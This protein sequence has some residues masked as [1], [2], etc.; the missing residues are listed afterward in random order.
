[1][2]SPSEGDGAPNEPQPI[3][4]SSIAIQM[5]LQQQNSM[6]LGT[7]DDH[8]S[9]V[10]SPEQQDKSGD[11]SDDSIIEVMAQKESKP[12]TAPMCKK[13]AIAQEDGNESFDD[14]NGAGGQGSEQMNGK[15]ST[16]KMKEVKVV[17]TNR[18]DKLPSTDS[19]HQIKKSTKF[20]SI[21]SDSNADRQRSKAFQTSP[22]YAGK[23]VCNAYAIQLQRVIS[24]SGQQCITALQLLT[25][26]FDPIHT[27]SPLSIIDS[28]VVSPTSPVTAQ[29][30]PGDFVPVGTPPPVQNKQ[31]QADHP[32]LPEGS[33]TIPLVQHSDST[34]T[35]TLS[36]P[37]PVIPM[38][39]GNPLHNLNYQDHLSRIPTTEQLSRCTPSQT[40]TPLPSVLTLS[41]LLWWKP[42]N[43]AIATQYNL[44]PFGICSSVG[45]H[46]LDA[47]FPLGHLTY[48]FNTSLFR[49]LL[50][51]PPIYCPAYKGPFC[52]SIVHN[53]LDGCLAFAYGY[54]HFEEGSNCVSLRHYSTYMVN[55]IHF[56]PQLLRFCFSPRVPANPLKL[57]KN[58]CLQ[59]ID[60]VHGS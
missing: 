27:S 40:P 31:Q 11:D 5:L 46:A 53:F 44:T 33:L 23:I 39:S 3:C 43:T 28:P 18:D 59:T 2:A 54:L 29:P 13:V 58:Y 37:P 14:E 55:T 16:Q 32:P 51:L 49:K 45:I 34:L 30:I 9:A 35:N 22:P 48:I 36:F 50:T 15:R 1:M 60:L 4:Q 24:T 56:N 26:K 57:I 10:E 8:Y 42:S 17:V 7:D 20:G 41:T 21:P 25:E 6:D 38:S 47:D 12:V 19:R 52:L